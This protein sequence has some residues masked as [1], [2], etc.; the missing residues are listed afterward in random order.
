MGIEIN[1]LKKG[2]YFLHREEPCIIKEIG[3]VVC[4]THS[5]AKMKVT[6]NGIFSGFHETFSMPLHHRVE[7]LGIIRKAAQIIAKSGDSMQIMDNVTFETIDATA[8]KELFEQLSEGDTITF[9]EFGN[10]ARVIEK[11][12]TMED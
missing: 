3:L 10:K 1:Q 8:G 9:V 4:G 5:H 12:A 11:R 2:D 6:V 7:H